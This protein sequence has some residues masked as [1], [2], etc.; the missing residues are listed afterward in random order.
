MYN[1]F[2]QS[3]ASRAVSQP[4]VLKQTARSETLCRLSAVGCLQLQSQYKITQR[5]SCTLTVWH[6]Y[7]CATL[8]QP[9]HT[10]KELLLIALKQTL[11]STPNML[12]RMMF[13][14]Q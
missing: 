13:L 6:I 4:C 2:A 10:S 11:R 7:S 3:L 8:A 12:N 9:V 5:K 14:L 1:G